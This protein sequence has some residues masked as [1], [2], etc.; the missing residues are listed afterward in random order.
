M[1][2][3]VFI[4][5]GASTVV[6]P[7]AAGKPQAVRIQRMLAILLSAL[8]LLAITHSGPSVA[9]EQHSAQR[10]RM[11]AEIAAIARETGGAT[12]R[13]TFREAVMAAMARVPRHRFL[14]PV[15]QAFV[16]TSGPILR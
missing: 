3:R 15:Q 2:R 8:C 12:G 6:A 4:V 14:P 10:A 1:D 13:P 9:Q 11:V 7:P 5:R 16:A